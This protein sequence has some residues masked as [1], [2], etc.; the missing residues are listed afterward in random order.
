M[1]KIID[2]FSESSSLYKKFRPDYPD[3]LYNYL[4]SLVDS[5]HKAWDCGTGNGQV[6]VMLAQ[7]FKEVKAT[8]I[9]Q[10][11]LDAA[12][13]L[14]NIEYKACRA[15]QTPFE[16]NSF[17]LITVAQAVHWFDFEA[18]YTEVQRVAKPQA[19]LAVW[20]YG[21]LKIT[22]EIDAYIQDFYNQIIAAYWNVERKYIDE[23]YQ[24]IPFP[25][26]EIETPTF[27]ITKEWKLKDLEGY[28]NTWSAVKRYKKTIGE[29]PVDKLITQ[30]SKV[31]S[32]ATKHTVEFPIFIR[33][34]RL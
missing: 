21:L 14:D 17:D 9:S 8:D 7:H 30:L 24:T 32:A 25:F 26:D 23:A 3:A 29:N 19:I 18:F 34:A 5:T 11:Q 10:Q 13:K 28:L 22:D 12:T 20:G 27:S 15:G 16:D 1:K 6:A 2:N 31:W 4:L 33:I